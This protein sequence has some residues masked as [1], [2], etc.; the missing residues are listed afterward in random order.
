MLGNVLKHRGEGKVFNLGF[1]KTGTTSFEKAMSVM[2][3]HVA[4]GHWGYNYTYYLTAMAVAEEWDEI[5]RFT[6]IF[7][8]FSDGPWG[9]GT[10]LYKVLTEHLPEAKF[11]MTMR[12]AENWYKSFEKQLMF[13]DKD[14]KTALDTYRDHLFGSG[15]WFSKVFDIEKIDGNKDKIIEKYNRYNFE[16]IEHFKEIGRELLILDFSAGDDWKKLCAFLGRTPPD[17][18]FPAMNR[19]NPDWEKRRQN[20]LKNLSNYYNEPLA[21]S[22]FMI[23]QAQKKKTPPAD[24]SVGNANTSSQNTHLEDGS[25]S[26]AGD[27][28]TPP[29]LSKFHRLK[30][31][32]GIGRKQ[33]K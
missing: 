20:A 5:L 12:P 32:S 10:E 17:Q 26:A 29:P 4:H 24:S 30:N 3:Y 31:A 23:N 15:Y 9:G 19:T 13:F 22:R 25:T 6:N 28:S 21:K 2:G 8:V 33:I 11:I 14:P 27:V 18:P 1:S 7:D 16:V